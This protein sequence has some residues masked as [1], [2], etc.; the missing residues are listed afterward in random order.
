MVKAVF[1]DYMG[2]TVDEHSPE[3]TEI[4]GRFC[5]HSIL[6]DPKQVLWFILDTRRH[7]EANGYL[8]AY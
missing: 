6:H 8:D 5:K 7:Y 4:V 3:M 2:T 1:I